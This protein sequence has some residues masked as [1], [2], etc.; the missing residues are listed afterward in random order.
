VTA[1]GQPFEPVAPFIGTGEKM[2]HEPAFPINDR[3]VERSRSR[4]RRCRALSAVPHTRE[5]RAFVGIGHHFDGSGVGAGQREVPDAGLAAVKAM[6][7]CIRNRPQPVS[8]QIAS[9]A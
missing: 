9:R 4:D 2:K 7:F 1:I 6:M 5:R 8:N 3:L